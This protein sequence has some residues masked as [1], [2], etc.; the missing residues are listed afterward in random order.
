[1]VATIDRNK[2]IVLYIKNVIVYGKLGKK[3]NNYT[4]R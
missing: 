3:I 1:M 2:N 4:I